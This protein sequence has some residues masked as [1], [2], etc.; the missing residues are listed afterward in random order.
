[1]GDRCTEPWHSECSE[2]ES[3]CDMDVDRV[4]VVGPGLPG[5]WAPTGEPDATRDECPKAAIQGR[6]A[7]TSGSGCNGGDNAPLEELSMW[8]GALGNGNNAMLEPKPLVT[9]GLDIS[10]SST[11][12][13]TRCGDGD[14]VTFSLRSRLL[15]DRATELFGLPLSGDRH[16]TTAT[17][18][19]G[20]C[21]AA[22]ANLGGRGCMKH[23]L[24]SPGSGL[25]ICRVL[26][27]STLCLLTVVRP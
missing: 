17:L 5:A 19:T 23:R 22:E 1:M 15:D 25:P 8:F 20:L 4:N 10:N 16:S 21:Q 7:P 27:S 9:R 26:E 24:L 11:S 6:G 2:T 12:L 3:E 18:L 13:G 14:S